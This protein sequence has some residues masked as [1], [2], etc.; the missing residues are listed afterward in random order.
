MVTYRHT[1]LCSNEKLTT[2]KWNH[3]SI[4]RQFILFLSFLPQYILKT[5]SPPPLPPAIAPFVHSLHRK[6]ELSRAT[7]CFSTACRWPCWASLPPSPSE[8]ALVTATEASGWPG[9][10]SL[11]PTAHLPSCGPSVASDTTRQTVMVKYFLLL[12]SIH[13]TLMVC[14]LS[15]QLL[16][17]LQAASSL[18]GWID[19]VL[20]CSVMSN[21]LHP[22]GLYLIRLLCPWNFAGKDTGVGCH[23][24]LQGIFPTQGSNPCLLCLL[25]L[26]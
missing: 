22:H 13:L 6:K 25:L 12:V 21:S 5:Q 24:L 10:V 9:P 17:F 19:G 8:Y 4:N 20:R 3:F 2:E 11:L 18:D 16:L 23:F 26:L 15:L 14:F 1:H 7:V